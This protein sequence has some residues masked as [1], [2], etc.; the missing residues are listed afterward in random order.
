MSL[1]GRL[2]VSVSLAGRKSHLLGN[3]QGIHDDA[4]LPQGVVQRLVKLAA[5]FIA[6]FVL[7]T[8]WYDFHSVSQLGLGASDPFAIE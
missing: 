6:E 3:S 8:V 4:F 7:D 2:E 1:C 5:M